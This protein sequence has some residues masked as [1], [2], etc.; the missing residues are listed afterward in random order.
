MGVM[1]WSRIVLAGCW[2]SVMLIYLLGDVLRLFAGSFTPGHIGNEPAKN[3]MWTVAALTMLIPIAM[4]LTTLLTPIGPLK[5][6]TITVSIALVI[7]N[8]SGLPYKDFF[9][10]MLIVISLGLNGFIVL[11]AW[12][13]QVTPEVTP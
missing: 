3:W 13:V 6:I 8:L 2:V 12:Q 7:F 10:N 4:I 1:A 5:W 9:D 11:Y